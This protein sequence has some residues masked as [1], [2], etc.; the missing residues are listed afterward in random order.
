MEIMQNDLLYQ[1]FVV[2]TDGSSFNKNL[3]LIG[4]NDPKSN[5]N[6]NSYFQ[7]PA[8]DDDW[9]NF[10]E[11]MN[12]RLWIGLRIVYRRNN[13]HALIEIHEMYPIYGRIWSNFYNSDQSW[14]GWK[15]ITPE[16]L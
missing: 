6:R 15:S 13:V 12:G 14:Q 10:P 7:K 2:S 3:L 16:S 5:Y 1:N 9:L 8:S 11:S 4:L